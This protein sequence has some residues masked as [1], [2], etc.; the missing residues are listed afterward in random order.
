MRAAGGGSIV[1]T[2]SIAG[3]HGVAGAL[4]YVATKFAVRGMT[5]AAA[6]ELGPDGIRVNSVH[7]GAIDTPMIATDDY[8][9]VDREAHFAKIPAGRIGRPDEVAHLALFLASDESTYC[10]GSEFVADGGSSATAR[11]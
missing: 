4:A 3:L 2:S 5:K 6:I 10:T 1:N 7:P 9:D 11:V 8:A